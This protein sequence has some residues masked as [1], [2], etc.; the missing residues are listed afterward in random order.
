[1]IAELNWPEFAER[2]IILRLALL[3]KI[4]HG[5]VI[6]LANEFL[7]SSEEHTRAPHEYKFRHT[8]PN[9]DSF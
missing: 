9:I 4:V 1:M 6:I 3:Y 2:R 7:I 8:G 5:N